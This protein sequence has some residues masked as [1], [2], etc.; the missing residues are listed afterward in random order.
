M[1]PKVSVLMVRAARSSA[2]LNPGKNFSTPN[3]KNTIP[4]LTLRS[5]I[6][7]RAIHSVSCSSNRSTSTLRVSTCFSPAVRPSATC[8]SRVR[9]TCLRML[10]L[11]RGRGEYREHVFAPR[12]RS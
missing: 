7:F 2:G 11:V 10:W 3:Q 6:A 1:I 12:N 8:A 5:A 9:V 4:R